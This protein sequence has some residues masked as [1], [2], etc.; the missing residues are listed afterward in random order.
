MKQKINDWRPETTALINRLIAAGAK[1]QFGSNG[2]D[3]MPWVGEESKDKFVENLIACDEA[4]LYV[5]INGHNLWLYLVLGNSPGEIVSD[6]QC[7]EVL[8]KVVDAHYAEWELKGQP[9]RWSE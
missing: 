7:D 4:R 9:L 2:E 8:D 1:I 6:Y 3:S 5:Q